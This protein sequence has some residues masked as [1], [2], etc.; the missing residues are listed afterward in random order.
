LLTALLIV[1]GMTAP[2][3]ASARPAVEYGIPG[4]TAAEG[5]L[6]RGLASATLARADNA[7]R[8]FA[9]AAFRSGDDRG[10]RLAGSER[11][12]GPTA[13]SDPQGLSYRAYDPTG[14]PKTDP[15][16]PA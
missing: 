7:G 4:R 3:P 8:I 14:P 9:A 12:Y 5:G 2:G 16:Q 6:S 15:S 13:A 10:P 1:M 11:I